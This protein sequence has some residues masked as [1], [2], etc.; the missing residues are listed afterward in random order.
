MTCF[1]RW[2]RQRDD[3]DG[4]GDGCDTSGMKIDFKQTKADRQAERLVNAG[5]PAGV[6]PP[7]GDLPPLESEQCHKPPKFKGGKK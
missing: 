7:N 5:L 1:R 4:D 6:P 3:P 2:A